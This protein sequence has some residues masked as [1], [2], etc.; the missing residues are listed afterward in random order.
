MSNTL[1]LYFSATNTTKNIA[2]IIANELNAD[3][4]PIKAKEPY[5]AADLDWHDPKSRTSIEQH[6]HISRV[7][8]VEDLPDISNYDNIIIG[9]PIWWGIPPRL[10]AQT[11]DDLPLSNKTLASFGTSGGSTYERSRSFMERTLNEN[12]YQNITFLNSDVLNSSSQAKRW[13]DSLKL[14]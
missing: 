11:I 9:H 10:I 2:Q 12:N 14:A 6:E 5:S 1:V 7:A 3:L 4:F 8:I 13:A